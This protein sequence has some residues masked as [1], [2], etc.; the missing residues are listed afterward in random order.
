[1]NGVNLIEENNFWK[2][3]AENNT[4]IQH[5]PSAP[6]GKERRF[7]RFNEEGTIG[8]LSSLGWP[9]L[10]LRDAP[11]GGLRTAGEWCYDDMQREF[12][13]ISK[14]PQNDFDAKLQV[15]SDAKDAALQ[16]IGYIKA[17][18]E[19]GDTCHTIIKALDVAS[20]GYDILEYASSDGSF[21]GVICRIRFRAGIDWEDTNYGPLPSYSAQSGACFWKSFRTVAGQ[22]DYLLPE[23]YNAV[24]RFVQHGNVPLIPD[25]QFSLVNVGTYGRFRFVNPPFPIENN[26]YVNVCYTK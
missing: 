24:I 12:R 14:V 6:A 10:E 5:N 11:R 15:Q 9:R 26:E 16:V 20:F 22:V 18:Q 3:I 25:E 7:A 4:Y 8:E 19:N 2:F 23:L 13:I 21:A 17:A 1:M